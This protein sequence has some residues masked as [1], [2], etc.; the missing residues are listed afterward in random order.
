MPRIGTEG[1]T[2]I[3]SRTLHPLNKSIRALLLRNHLLRWVQSRVSIIRSLLSRTKALWSAPVG[4]SME[5]SPSL[6]G[7]T[8]Y[9]WTPTCTGSGK[10]SCEIA[11]RP[12]RRNLEWNG[13]SV[14]RRPRYVSAINRFGGGGRPGTSLGQVSSLVFCSNSF[15]LFDDLQFVLERQ[16]PP[17][18]VGAIDN[19]IVITSDRALVLKSFEDLV[20]DCR[21]S[22]QDGTV[23]RHSNGADRGISSGNLENAPPG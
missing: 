19:Q 11:Q 9:K 23:P 3:R 20:A 7:E 16:R 14:A 4:W 17:T 10:D 8:G 22:N 13:R 21:Q 12:W 15:C 18:A 5:F 1:R 6:I 2:H